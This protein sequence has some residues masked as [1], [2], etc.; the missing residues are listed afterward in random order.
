MSSVPDSLQSIPVIWQIR[1]GAVASAEIEATL[2]R[3]ED[4]RRGIPAVAKGLVAW[5]TAL[6]G[7][8]ALLASIAR[9]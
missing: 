7:N 4:D 9:P 1:V 2:P 5:E 6:F 3:L 8:L